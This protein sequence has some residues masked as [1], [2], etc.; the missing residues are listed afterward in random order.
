MKNL[1]YLLSLLVLISS[2]AS[3]D[4]LVERGEYNKAFSLAVKKLTGK[5]NKKTKYV[6]GLEKAFRKLMDRDLKHVSN[7]I[8]KDNPKYWDDIYETYKG[9]DKRQREV[10]PLLPLVSKDGY[11]ATFRFIKTGSLKKTAS[12]KA[13]DYFYTKG[14]NYMNDARRGDKNAAINAYKSLERIEKYFDNYKDTNLLLKEAYELGQTRVL[15]KMENASHSI[16]PKRFERDLFGFGVRNLDTRWNKFY[17]KED[18]NIDYDAVATYKITFIE[19]SPEKEIINHVT[20]TKE[21]KDGW[22]YVMDRNGNVLKD[23]LGNDVKKDVYKVISADVANVI[24][25]KSVGLDG[26]LIVMDLNENRQLLNKE[27][28]GEAVF[29]EHFSTYRG[30]RNA[31]SKE[32]KRKLRNRPMHFPSDEELLLRTADELKEEISRAL[33]RLF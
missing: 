1:L 21:I 32:T 25:E 2:C 8:E 27:L 26:Y 10:E 4:K 17:T 28:S 12:N 15:V 33:R 19:T 20:E 11:K 5:K 9:I 29:D 30:D 6:K 24:M 13:S 14:V 18:K 22:E 7:L 16:L 31:L 3:I 23:S